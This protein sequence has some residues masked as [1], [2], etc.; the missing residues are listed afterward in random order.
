MKERIEE[1][2][3]QL[4]N[5][6]RILVWYDTKEEFSKVYEDLELGDV[7]KERLTHN[8]FAIKYKVYIKYPEQK[9]LLYIPYKRPADEYNWLLDIEESNKLFS[10][11][12]VALLLQDLELPIRLEM[13]EWVSLHLDFFQ[14]KERMQTFKR[15]LQPNETS[16][17]LN[18]KLCQVIFG[19]DIP[20]IDNM[21]QV[22]TQAYVEGSENNLTAEL[23]RFNVKDFFW[24]EV[25]RLYGIK[26]SFKESQLKV[27]K[28]T[29][30]DFIIQLFR[31][32]WKVTATQSQL[33]EAAIVLVN[34]WKD[35]KKFSKYFTELSHQLEDELKIASLVAEVPLEQ[36]I[37]ED[38]YESF[39]QEII[40][41][42]V[43]LTSYQS[44]DPAKLLE[45]IKLRSHTYW[46][47][48]QYRPYYEALAMAIQYKKYSFNF[49]E[50]SCYSFGDALKSYTT[51]W[52][53]VD[54]FYRKFIQ[55]YRETHSSYILYDLAKEIE[56]NYTNKW[57]LNQSEKWQFFL[58]KQK[59]WY[60][61]EKSQ[62][63]FFNYFLKPRFLDANR[64]VFVIVS[65]ALRYECGVELHNH[66]M[67]SENRLSSSLDFLVTGLPSYTQLGMAALLPHKSLKFMNGDQIEID[68]MSSVGTAGRAKV[69]KTNS[70]VKATAVTAEEVMQMTARGVESKELVQEH[71][72]IYI[73]HNLID[74]VGDDKTSE[75]RLVEAVQEE[76]DYLISLIKKLSN[77]NANHI[78]LTADHGFLYQHE[79]LEES[80][81]I[82]EDLEGDIM[83]FNRRYILGREF[84]PNSNFKYYLAKDLRVDSDCI[85]AL[86][87][88]LNRLRRKGSGSRYVHGGASLQE[89][90]TPLLYIQRK[91]KDTLR[92]VDVDIINQAN[93]RIT[94][95]QHRIQFYQ[96]EPIGKGIVPRDIKAYFATSEKEGKQIISDIF[97]CTLDKQENRSEDREV[98]YLFTLSTHKV[99]SSDVYLYVEGRIGDSN[100]WEELMRLKYKLSIAIERDFFF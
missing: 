93:N 79:G 43:S 68:G 33:N 63:N 2:L 15:L 61:D 13:K 51:E 82:S 74:K 81:Y 53:K 23:I 95:N 59:A 57:L 76:L 50:L 92:E 86:P 3:L 87:K 64:K 44:K 29:I 98:E 48:K 21:L 37:Q 20:Q 67:H 18:L 4:F 58:D 54:Y 1:S 9:F 34:S 6:H 27:D 17:T 42:L 40:R 72:L 96:K 14:N 39:D 88:G 100:Q 85:V 45:L 69:V 10:T 46:Y 75:D 77:M 16:Y 8:E 24:Q 56:S 70:G 35:S 89:C 55:Y 99:S 19:C 28:L 65:D 26:N 38:L 5:K 32:N 97:S 47:E 22:Y 90:I 31:K 11:D 83:V 62:H 66:I 52:Y 41:G 84:L 12:Q 78:I 25:I 7:A 91:R 80:D 71:D 49:E 30:A 36:L 60:F 94:T 73:Y